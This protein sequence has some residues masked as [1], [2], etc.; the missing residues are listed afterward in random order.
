[1]TPTC[2]SFH[3]TF[4][5]G[6]ASQ[7]SALDGQTHSTPDVLVRLGWDDPESLDALADRWE[8]ELDKH[9]VSRAALI[10]SSPGDAPAV[11]TAV[12]RH[13]TRFV[14]FFM[15]DPTRSDA[16]R[17]R[18]PIA[19]RGFAHDVPLPRHALLHAAR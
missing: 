8:D 5:A 19:R 4:F 10:A 18:H 6:L 13:P 3:R 17:V 12:A 14:G 1:M 15:A 11:A 9:G 16:R 2:I 7:L